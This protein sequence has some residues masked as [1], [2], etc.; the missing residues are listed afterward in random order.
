MKK[1]SDRATSQTKPPAKLLLGFYGDDFTGSTDV[2]E[3]LT[4]AGLR[5]V[6]FLHPPTGSQLRQFPGLRAFGVAGTG[7]TMSPAQ[8]DQELTPLFRRLR[9][10]GARL[11]HYK[12][13]STFDS[14]PEIGSIGRAID[15]GQKVFRSEF[16]PL[17]V[18]APVLGRYSVFGN[19]FARSGLD[20]EPHRLDRHPTMRQHP[21]TPMDE[22]DLRLHLGKQTSRPITLF[23][24]L[25]LEAPDAGKRFGE[26]LAG[27]GEIVLFDVLNNSHLPTIGSLIWKHAKAGQPLFAAGSSGLEYA[28]T[29]YWRR[30]GKLGLPTPPPTPRPVVPVLVVSGSCSPVTERQIRRALTKGYVEIPLDVPAL[31]TPDTAEKVME[32]TVRAAVQ[33]LDSHKGVILHTS[34]GPDD[35][36]LARSLQRLMSLGDTQTQARAGT[37]GLLGG[38]LGKLLLRVLAE[39]PV[40]RL[41]VTG[42]DTS[43][44]VAR[45]LGVEALEPVGPLAPGGPLCRMHAPGWP[46]HQLEIVFKGGQVGNDAFFETLLKGGDP[47]LWRSG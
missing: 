34:L 31:V 2:M 20:S 39:R 4:R 30:E 17:V 26:L 38:I 24:I 14:S 7:R 33:K 11:V 6:L 25:K 40:Q 1:Q 5:T 37:A 10:S 9:R 22:S 19:L 18:G 23:D 43:T 21:T 45:A 29:A 46:T 32:Q 42:G 36:R 12:I 13:C 8:M 16:V 44:H 47:A 41:A 3:S 35:S 28:L 15:L 27:R